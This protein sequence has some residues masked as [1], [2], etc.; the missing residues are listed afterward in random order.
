VGNACAVLAEF[1]SLGVLQWITHIQPQHS[2][3][4]STAILGP[5]LLLFKE[6]LLKC[7][8]LSSINCFLDTLNSIY[9]S[10]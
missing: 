5:L 1:S 9:L 2:L 6:S 4:E 8:L 3:T 7:T 10:C